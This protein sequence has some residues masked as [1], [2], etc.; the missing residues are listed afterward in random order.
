MDVFWVVW[1]NYFFLTKINLTVLWT[2]GKMARLGIEK[3]DEKLMWKI[4]ESKKP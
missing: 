2:M 4:L 3:K 1:F